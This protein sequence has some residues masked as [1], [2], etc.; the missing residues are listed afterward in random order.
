MLTE[1]EIEDDYQTVLETIFGYVYFDTVEHPEE[2]ELI[3]EE[4]QRKIDES[5]AVLDRELRF[6]GE[7]YT[8]FH[9]VYNAVKHRNRAIHKPKTNSNSS[10][11][12]ATTPRLSRIR[13]CRMGR[14]P[15]FSPLSLNRSAS[16]TLLG[17]I[18]GSPIDVGLS[19]CNE[20]QEACGYRAWSWET[21]TPCLRCAI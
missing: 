17:R 4:L 3:H 16:R 7:F 18:E 10:R 20:P 6:V 11:A 13:T 14:A 21:N 5:T 8:M 12:R 15:S 19:S 9:D 1:N 2:G